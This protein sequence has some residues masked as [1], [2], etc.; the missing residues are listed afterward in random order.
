VGELTLACSPSRGTDG[1]CAFGRSAGI[2]GRR[3]SRPDSVGPE[4]RLNGQDPRI[5]SRLAKGQSFVR[6]IE[7]EPSD[8]IAKGWGLLSWSSCRVSGWS[9]RWHGESKGLAGVWRTQ[10]GRINR[11]RRAG[12]DLAPCIGVRLARPVYENTCRIIRERLVGGIATRKGQA[13]RGP[14]PGHEIGRLRRDSQEQDSDWLRISGPNAGPLPTGLESFARR[15]TS[16]FPVTTCASSASRALQ[17]LP[18]IQGAF[19]QGD[20]SSSVASRFCPPA[21]PVWVGLGRGTR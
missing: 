8:A 6:L 2:R 4:D 19:F 12:P 15:F 18:F 1:L 14:G 7:R 13:S 16:L 3:A 9:S 20:R 11:S 21:R 5:I 17:L 10:K